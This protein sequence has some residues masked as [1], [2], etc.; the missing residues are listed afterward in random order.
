MNNAP[1][2]LD[3]NKIAELLSNQSSII[4]LFIVLFVLVLIYYP[5]IVKKIF[6]SGNG[7]FVLEDKRNKTLLIDFNKDIDCP[8][9]ICDKII[10]SN[11]FHSQKNLSYVKLY[12]RITKFIELAEPLIG[13]T[14]IIIIFVLTLLL[15]PIFYILMIQSGLLFKSILGF[16]PTILSG[17]MLLILKLNYDEINKSISHISIENGN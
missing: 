5:R 12:L 14:G 8:K 13:L 7:L 1:P 3:L 15:L 4:I 17:L 9:G 10:V 16:L 2:N 11:L 6:D